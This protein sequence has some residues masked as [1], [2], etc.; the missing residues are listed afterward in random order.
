MS[1]HRYH[2]LLALLG[3]GSAHP[4]GFAM[5]VALLSRLGLH[6][7]MRVLDAGCG[8][9]RTACYIA[10]QYGC[11]VTGVD[12]HPMMIRKAVKRARRSSVS[13]QWVCGNVRE[14]PFPAESF[15]LV[16][17]ESVTVF[18][19]DNEAIG[20]YARVL[21]PRG[22][23]MDL[24]LCARGMIPEEQ[25]RL[26]YGAAKLPSAEEW[27]NRYRSY[28]FSRV[29]LLRNRRLSMRQTLRSEI[30]YP[31][32]HRFVSKGI[33]KQPG[34]TDTLALNGMFLAEYETCLG[35]V[36]IEARK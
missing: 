34:L 5:S 14:L 23:I 29:K 21:K 17:A 36:A 6:A 8:T 27:M 15:D 24:E 4:G 28:G 3:E 7:G 19:P 33:H 1:S 18:M 11:S 9:G 2:D 10:Q 13:V 26:I 31:D 16:I 25:V 30:D 12:A 32:P 22:R 35:L 20:E